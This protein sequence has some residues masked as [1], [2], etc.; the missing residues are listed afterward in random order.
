MVETETTPEETEEEKPSAETEGREIDEE[1]EDYNPHYFLAQEL[2]NQ[3]VLPEE[4]EIG[5]D[6]GYS[7]I[8]NHYRDR[9]KAPL[10]AE[11]ESELRQEHIQ[12]GWTE[13]DLF[14]AR[15]WRQGVDPR[16][17]A[18][19][20]RLRTYGSIDIEALSDEDKLTVVRSMYE[21]RGTGIEEADILIKAREEAGT[22]AELLQEA[23][24]FHKTQYESWAEQERARQAQYQEQ[25]NAQ[26]TA[27]Q[28]KVNNVIQSRQVSGLTITSDQAKD[29]HKDI[30]EAHETVEVDGK[31]Q[32]VPAVNKFL[33]EFQNNV[34]LQLE[35]YLLHKYRDRVL[36]ATKNTAV[37]EVE[38][39]LLEASGRKIKSKKTSKKPPKV[40]DKNMESAR[41]LTRLN[42]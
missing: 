31:L 42:F 29:L 30:Y 35:L 15:A 7:D 21:F 9:M 10:R 26:R 36:Q 20:E 18:P 11:L 32:K 23:V 1:Q 38:Q 41:V 2:R 27:V 40:A 17:F 19:A 16:S 14:Y 8:V 3:G 12:N 6:V 37:G 4:F 25:V 33:Y 39:A 22:S 13:E 5:E 28:N 34:E 24:N